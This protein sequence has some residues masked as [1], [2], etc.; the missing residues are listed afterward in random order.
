M[1]MRAPLGT[2]PPARAETPPG[3]GGSPFCE[4]DGTSGSRIQAVYGHLPGQ[5]DN[6]AA[7]LPVFR[8]MASAIDDAFDMS[9]GRQGGSAHPRW[10]FEPG[11]CNLSVLNV[12]LPAG[13]NDNFNLTVQRLTDLGL[14]ARSDRKY[15]VWLDADGTNN[16]IAHS[17]QSTDPNPATNPADGGQ[18]LATVAQLARNGGWD[19][20]G[21][22]GPSFAWG[23]QHELTH[24][25]G[26]VNPA[27][28]HHRQGHCSDEYDAMCFSI[29]GDPPPP[30]DGSFVALKLLLDCNADDYFAVNPPPG[31]YLANNWNTYN[32]SFLVRTDTP[33][34]PPDTAIDSGPSGTVA[35]TTAQFAFS[36]ADGASFECSLDGGAFAACSSPKSY[37]DLPGGAHAFAV[38]AVD[39]AGNRDY[40][41]AERA[42]TVSGGGGGGGGGGNADA[43]DTEITKSKVKKR[44]AT[45]EFEGS[46]GEGPLTFECSLDGKAFAGCRSPAKFKRLKPGR[47]TF[48]VRA[49]DANG[50][51]PTP[52]EKRF[53]IKR[54]RRH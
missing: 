36:S 35:E 38:R 30:C 52:A 51:D 33:D 10:A 19:T 11:T 50:A 49:K 9:A 45:F 3:P 8:T 15:I 2:A 13:A 14:R 1:Q 16:L 24:M 44:K 42:W 20:D 32:S 27:A 46:G 7:S 22:G 4:G 29:G 47:H 25:L 6:Y 17:P 12:E 48:A 34:L 54:K 37:P 23:P 39:A 40:T 43:P 5:P 53:K 41:P 28:P 31:N 26:A 21:F 18:G